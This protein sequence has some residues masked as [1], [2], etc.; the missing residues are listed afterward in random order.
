MITNRSANWISVATL[1]E[2][3]QRNKDQLQ[4]QDV[5]LHRSSLLLVSFVFIPSLPL[6]FS[7]FS[8]YETDRNRQCDQ[9]T[10]TNNRRSRFVD[11]IV[12]DNPILTTIGHLS[13]GY[14]LRRIPIRRNHTVSTSARHVQPSSGAPGVHHQRCGRR[15]QAGDL[16]SQ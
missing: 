8:P 1:V 7:S 14:S 5:C 4:V 15:R 6:P 11:G 9:S 3:R 13:L 12:I 16:F 10:R 2:Y